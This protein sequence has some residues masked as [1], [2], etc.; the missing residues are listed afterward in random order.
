MLSRFRSS[1]TYANVMATV[2]VFVALGGTSYA[3]ATGSIGSR[4]IENNSVRGKDIR[5]RTIRVRDV[6]NPRALL[7]GV[8]QIREASMDPPDLVANSCSTG[9]M[10]VQGIR[11]GDHVLVTTSE[12]L[13]PALSVTSL[14]PTVNDNVRVRL[15]NHTE[16]AVTGEPSRPFLVLAFHP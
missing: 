4:E 14:I 1:L 15:C 9:D 7:G 6:Q 2:A 11:T 16:A 10:D 12:D 13:D 3:V 8:L 5:D